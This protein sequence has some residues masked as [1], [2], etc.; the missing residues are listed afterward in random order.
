MAE[1]TGGGQLITDVDADRTAGE[2]LRSASA[3]TRSCTA[4]EADNATPTR[5]N[6]Q[7]IWL[8]NAFQ[9][10]ASQ[11]FEMDEEYRWLWEGLRPE[12][13][14]PQGLSPSLWVCLCFKT[15]NWW[16]A[17][18]HFRHAPPQCPSSWPNACK[19][20]PPAKPSDCSAGTDRSSYAPASQGWLRPHGFSGVTAQAHATC[21]SNF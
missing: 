21:S 7:I 13:G 12:E 5:A 17:C 4:G 10:R 6:E 16:T 20:K 14:G 9:T 8:R 15:A 19:A 11:L 2:E 18:W 3:P 1:E